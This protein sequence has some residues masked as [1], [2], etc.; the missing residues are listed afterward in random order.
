MLNSIVTSALFVGIAGIILKGYLETRTERR[1]E[2]RE[3]LLN[4]LS[5]IDEIY[6]QAVE[7]AKDSLPN[8]EVQ[9]RNEHKKH[10]KEKKPQLFKRN[11]EKLFN[12]ILVEFP[13]AFQYYVPF[14]GQADT[15]PVALILGIG[16]SE[17]ERS[18]EYFLGEYQAT[19]NQ[20]RMTLKGRL[21]YHHGPLYNSLPNIWNRILRKKD[22]DGNPFG[23]VNIKT[24]NFDDIKAHFK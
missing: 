1:K 11:R 21:S 7:I 10:E 13:D 15:A 3:A 22:K 12:I 20:R 19:I 9:E 4:C 24:V 18:I 14:E 8:D 6:W 16:Q 5:L 23:M 2:K 17:K